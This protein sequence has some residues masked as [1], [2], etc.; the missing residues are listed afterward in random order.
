MTA[1]RFP[2]PTGPC[3][4]A[5]KDGHERCWQH[6]D[7]TAV[8]KVAAAKE[9]A[10]AIRGTA[11]RRPVVVPD[12]SLRPLSDTEVARIGAA[13]LDHGVVFAII[14]GAALNMYDA[15]VERTRDVDVLVDRSVA[16]L[17]RLASA[18]N[19]IDARIWVGPAEPDGVATGWSAE[20]LG[21]NQRFLN[22]TTAIG[23]IDIN[24]AP[25]G[26]EGGY[27][28]VA[29]RVVTMALRDVLLPLAPLDAIVA[30][31]EAAGRPKDVAVLGKLR[32]WMRTRQD[33]EASEAEP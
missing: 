25:D 9:M 12:S 32:R 2:T 21:A 1:C 26:L 28:D 16:N 5:P 3:K 33:V 31:K 8:E 29:D 4:R 17:G 19:A 22:L 14:G 13:L 24:Y 15:P 27:G 11:L 7:A 6:V 10:L 30:S 20:L 23:P 18:L